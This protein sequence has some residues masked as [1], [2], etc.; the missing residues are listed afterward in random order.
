KGGGL[1]VNDGLPIPESRPPY[2]KRPLIAASFCF[3]TWLGF[4]IV[5][6]GP[7]DGSGTLYSEW[8]VRIRADLM[9]SCVQSESDGD[10]S[11]PKPLTQPG[12]PTSA[13]EF[14]DLGRIVV[15]VDV[16]QD[17][18]A[19]LTNELLREGS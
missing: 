13:Q 18:R 15:F 16:G 8:D 3:V 6:Y 7:L 19:D 2:L 11:S 4:T 9:A 14:F 5:V 1:R 12:S 10:G 17:K